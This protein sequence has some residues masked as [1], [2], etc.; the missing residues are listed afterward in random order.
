M[1]RTAAEP[2]L[3]RYGDPPQAENPVIQDFCSPCRGRLP[4]RKRGKTFLAWW[5]YK[6]PPK[7]NKSGHK[8]M[9]EWRS[10]L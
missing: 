2:E 3:C 6:F 10:E 8:I 7:C 4:F 9:S 1:D 5:R